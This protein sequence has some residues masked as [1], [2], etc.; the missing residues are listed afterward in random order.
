[1]VRLIEELQR[2]QSSIDLREL[3]GRRHASLCLHAWPGCRFPNCLHEI[4]WATGVGVLLLPGTSPIR[5]I[6]R[7]ASNRLHIAQPARSRRVMVEIHHV[8]TS[9]LL[10]Q[11][12][13]LRDF[14]SHSNVELS[15]GTVKSSPKPPLSNANA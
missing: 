11:H 5:Y 1:M 4:E 9:F 13:R 3:S 7:E 8:F 10:S 12:I 2:R 15:G 14:V 6:V